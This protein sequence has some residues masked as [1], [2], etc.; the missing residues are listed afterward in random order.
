MGSRNKREG[1]CA[2]RIRAIIPG[3]GSCKG[4]HDREEAMRLTTANTMTSAAII[5]LVCA[6]ALPARAQDKTPYVMKITAPTLNAAPDLFGRAFGAAVEK[7]SGGRIK[8]EVYPASQ[9][10]AVP[11]QIEGTQFGSIQCAMLPPEFFVGVDQRFEVLAAPGLVDSEKLGHRV[12]ADPAVQKMMLGLGA[13]KG[14]HGVGLFYAEPS[15]V[16][17]RTPIRH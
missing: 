10:G 13:D 2:A 6:A 4:P 7:E 5:A 14:L 8:A 17:A 12:A 11:R 3:K 1:G 15:L 9:L 16:A